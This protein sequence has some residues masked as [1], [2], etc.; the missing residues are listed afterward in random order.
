MS[1][2]MRGIE[3]RDELGGIH[4]WP[5]EDFDASTVRMPDGN[6]YSVSPAGVIE[7]E[8]DRSQPNRSISHRFLSKLKVL[9][10]DPGESSSGPP[11][12]KHV[13]YKMDHSN[14]MADEIPKPVVIDH[15]P[16]P[17]VDYCWDSYPDS[18]STPAAFEKQLVKYLK[19]A[20][21]LR[22]DPAKLLDRSTTRYRRVL[23]QDN[24]Y[25]QRFEGLEHLYPVRG[26]G[27]PM[28]QQVRR[29]IQCAV[30][31]GFVKDQVLDDEDTRALFRSMTLTEAAAV[32][33]RLNRA[34]R[35]DARPS[36][37]G[38]QPAEAGAPN[39]LA[40]GTGV[41]AAG[42]GLALLAKKMTQ[43]PA[44]EE[45]SSP[46]KAE[47]PAIEE[48]SS[49]PKA[50]L[51]K[52]PVIRSQRPKRGVLKQMP[53]ANNGD[54]QCFQVSVAA[55]LYY[56]GVRIKA[57]EIPND[58]V[59][60]LNEEFEKIGYKDKV[61]HDVKFGNIVEQLPQIQFLERMHQSWD[62]GEVFTDFGSYRA[63]QGEIDE[64]EFLQ[65]NHE[66]EFPKGENASA[67]MY[68]EFVIQALTFRP[69]NGY[70]GH[71]CPLGPY[72]ADERGDDDDDDDDS[73]PVNPV[74]FRIPQVAAYKLCHGER[75]SFVEGIIHAGETM[76]VLQSDDTERDY[77]LVRLNQSHEKNGAH[78]QERFTIDMK[79]GDPEARKTVTVS[80]SLAA[81]VFHC[82]N[83]L[84]YVFAGKY[85]PNDDS[86]ADLKWHLFESLPKAKVMGT[87]GCFDD[88]SHDRSTL[89]PEIALYSV[90]W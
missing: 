50:E 28:R 31:K 32:G 8:T 34:N 37:T 86:S 72:S 69:G 71:F 46:P 40:A 57:P 42:S 20:K 87:F 88:V 52:A 83:P 27:V 65:L 58:M 79:L 16:L 21:E 25:M 44:I 13:V 15:N 19:R 54:L 35:E 80:F 9:V 4:E 67:P 62:K 6:I 23:F 81:V 17:L 43:A 7:K 85:H 1:F 33:S 70:S 49:P 41:V 2:D 60:S 74:P 68:A 39:S 12:L 30:A 78:L 90:S 56:A 84:H 14:V 53:Y 38:A 5:D 10:S 73:P 22:Y 82:D 47:A 75:A 76:N 45:E 48:E 89:T 77:L 64:F 51:P 59:D 29:Y 3:Y 66:F 36:E 63:V 24:V 61:G 11:K 26:I 55:I 18:T